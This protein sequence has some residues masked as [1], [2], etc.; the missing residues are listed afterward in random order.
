VSHLLNHTSADELASSIRCAIDNGHPFE[1][2]RLKASLDNERKS[3]GPRKTII[4]LL[5]REIRRQE[6]GHA[7]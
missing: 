3:T 1:I 6:K 5:E 7:A 4:N 2:E